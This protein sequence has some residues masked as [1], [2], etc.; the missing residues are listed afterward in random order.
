MILEK[1]SN[2]MQ[3]ISTDLNGSEWT[4]TNGNKY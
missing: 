1:L 2:L 3:Q 4:W